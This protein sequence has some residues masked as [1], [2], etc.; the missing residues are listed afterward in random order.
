MLVKYKII[1]DTT[2]EFGQSLKEI[3]SL[4]P[5]LGFSR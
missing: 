1:A 4:L 5:E 2:F 3:L